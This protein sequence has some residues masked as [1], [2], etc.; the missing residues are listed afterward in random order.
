MNRDTL[1]TVSARANDL[2]MTI[3]QVLDS[4][5][6][7]TAD[8]LAS[9]R[10]DAAYLL[11]MLSED[12]PPQMLS[13]R[14]LARLYKELCDH[15]LVEWGVEELRAELEAT[16]EN[17][18]MSDIEEVN[19]RCGDDRDTLVAATLWLL[20]ENGLLPPIQWVCD[21]EDAS[22]SPTAFQL[23]GGGWWLFRVA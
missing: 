17:W 9:L 4:G 20:E 19:L 5:A 3:D 14:S 16:I 2:S 12:V 23:D 6:E 1:I 22:D 21:K 18:K 15:G 7:L 13:E 10:S 11:E 8:D